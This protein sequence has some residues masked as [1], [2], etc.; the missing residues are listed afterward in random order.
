MKRRKLICAATAAACTLALLGAPVPPA[1]H[2]QE[3][4]SSIKQLESEADALVSKISE[5]T[6]TY[7]EAEE[8]VNSLEE[9]IAQAE[10][11]ASELEQQLPEQRAR[12]AA[13]VKT[14]YKF[15]QSSSNLLELILSSESFDEFM[16]SLHYLDTIHEHNTKEI[17][18]L[19]GMVDELAKTKALLLS[20]RDAA[21]QKKEEALEALKQAR[22][23]RAELQA[24]AIAIAASEQGNRAQAIK[25]A[26]EALQSTTDAP[27]TFVSSSGNEAVLQVP[28]SADVSTDPLLS[29][30]TSDETSDWATRINAYLAGSPLEGYGETF[31]QAAATYGVDPR[32]S[33]AISTIESGKGSVCFND[34]NAWGWGNSSYS[35]WES[36]IYDQVEGLAKGYDGTL[37]LDGAQRYCPPNYEEWYS[38]VAN[39]MDGI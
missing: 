8:A 21:V 10:E 38:S 32:L 37:T 39:E 33:P 1:I 27:V 25:V 29:N 13:S 28:G 15:H 5:T 31:A 6:A 12:A 26:Q 20:Q 34:H 24:H 2:A 36:A 23:A 14:M 9:Q 4:P 35:D 19:N 7:Q 3:A 16:S 11:H 22:D 17:I 30:I 18:E